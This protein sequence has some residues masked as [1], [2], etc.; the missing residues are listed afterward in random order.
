MQELKYLLPPKAC[1]TRNLEL[2]VESVERDD[3][4]PLDHES[5]K[6]AI[7]GAKS[8]PWETPFGHSPLRS[9][10]PP[11]PIEPALLGFDG[12]PKATQN[13]ESRCFAL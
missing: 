6:P 7:V 8:A 5:Q 1:F 12:D 9:L 10:A 4:I 3:E 2:G 11:L 13:R